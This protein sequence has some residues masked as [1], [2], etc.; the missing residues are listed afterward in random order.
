VRELA[1]PESVAVERDDDGSI[2][3]VSTFSTGPSTILQRVRLRPGAS[4]IDIELDVDWRDRE[5]ILKL[6]MP[7]DLRADRTAAETQFGH[8]FRSTHTNTSWEAARFEA[9]QHRWL[10]LGEPGFGVAIANDS[11]YGYD[12]DRTTRE[13][14][15]TTTTARF[16]VLRAP[17][18][19]DPESDQG[20][21][22]VR[23]SVAP[24]AGIPE[25][26]ALGY[27]RNLPLRRVSGSPV[28][29]L[30]TSS[31]PGVVV[32]TVKLAEDRSGDVIVRVYESW[33]RRQSATITID[34]DYE[35]VALTDLL[36]RDLPGDAL[37]GAQ[38]TLRPFQFVTLRFRGVAR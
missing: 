3:V 18:F 9:V 14:G 34:A 6:A 37:Q 31:A 22:S 24:D 2:S 17:L 38:L 19:P 5:K 23:F 32:E 8:I 27:E 28:G 26:V 13:D 25:A 36:E 15:G 16:S 30:V 29:P 35:S 1:D 33:G 4:A 20:M 12:V 10:H 21:H 11:T 7:L